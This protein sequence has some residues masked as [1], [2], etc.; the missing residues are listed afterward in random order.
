MDKN[1]FNVKGIKD[2]EKLEPGSN[3]NLN[4][5][6]FLNGKSFV[7]SEKGEFGGIFGKG[8][9]KY[10]LLGYEKDHKSA[11]NLSGFNHIR[12]FA[13]FNEGIEKTFHSVTGCFFEERNFL[14]SKIWK[15][16]FED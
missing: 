7:G 10:L 13:L 1:Y 4:Y 6:Y 3:I 11:N 8:S 12:V 2:L 14:Y 15:E 16:F 5:F 9:L